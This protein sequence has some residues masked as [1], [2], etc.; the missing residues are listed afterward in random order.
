[1]I[2]KTL[3]AAALAASA[4]FALQAQAAPVVVSVGTD[5]FDG[6]SLLG[7]TLTGQLS[8]D[9]SSLTPLTD[10][11]PVIGFSFTVGGQSYALAGAELADAIVTFTNGLV[12]GLDA[13][14]LDTGTHDFAFSSGF[15]APFVFYQNDNDFGAAN[16]SFTATAAA[17]PEPAS[18]ALVLAAMGGV[19]LARRRQA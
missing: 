8:Y 6:G 9:D 3:L 15:G 11:L 16:L 19:L 12:T 14:M 17:V 10:S 5:A 4:G 7:K 1:M 2:R 13:V 18:C